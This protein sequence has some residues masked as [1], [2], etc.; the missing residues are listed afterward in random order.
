MAKNNMELVYQIEDMIKKYNKK[1]EKKIRKKDIVDILQK[2]DIIMAMRSEFDEAE[3]FGE[4]IEGVSLK[5]DIV[6]DGGRARLLPVF[7]SYEQ[8]PRD[9]MDSFSFIKVPA[10]YAYTF[11]NDCENLNGMVLN[12]FTEYNLE[13]RKKR[14]ASKAQVSATKHY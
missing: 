3:I 12:P 10:S 2:A 4:I 8:I 14:T 11:M 9:Y 1:P 5:P 7:T 13:L 6:K